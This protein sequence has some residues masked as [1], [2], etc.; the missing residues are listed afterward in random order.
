MDHIPV[1][2]DNAPG[3][4]YHKKDP[5]LRYFLTG[6]SDDFQEHTVVHSDRTR[7]VLKGSK[8]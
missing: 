2:Y 3:P 8:S 6:E 5:R 1:L 7:C 4:S